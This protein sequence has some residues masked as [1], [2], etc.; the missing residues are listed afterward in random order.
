MRTPAHTLFVVRHGEN[1][2][3]VNREF[4][5]KLVDYSLNARGIQQAEETA[6]HFLDK[7]IHEIYSSPL[8]RA[9]ETAEIIAAPLGLP[10]TVIEEFR[11]N[12]VGDLEGQPPSDENWALHDRIIADWYAGRHDS[13]FPGGEDFLTLIRRVKTGITHILND[14]P[15]TH[16]E[17]RIV[18]VAHG[19]I[20]NGMARGIATGPELGPLGTSRC[21]NCSV[22]EFEA[23]L[24]DGDLKLHLREWAACAHL[25]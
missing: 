1:P 11:E 21:P 19:G 16:D 24:V 20:L 12:N 5:Y 7:G 3:N 25:S 17:R 23:R 10:V 22:S 2:A 13:A 14:G 8:K 6:V 18:I 4:S 9:L 15:G